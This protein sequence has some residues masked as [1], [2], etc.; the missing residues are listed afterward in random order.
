MNGVMEKMAPAP[1]L[2][3]LDRPGNR[4]IIECHD[5]WKVF[6]NLPAEALAGLRERRLSRAEV[7]ERYGCVV[8]LAGISVRVEQGDICCVM[9]LSGSGKSTLVRH[10]NGL[11][12][13]TSGRVTVDGVD[14]TTAGA[15]LLRQIRSQKIG[16]VFQ[17]FGLLPHRSV[18][19]NVAFGL[20][21]RGVAQGLR[22]HRAREML[23]LVDLDGWEHSY[24]HQ[25]S[26]GMQQRVG[27]ARAL[28]SDPEILLLDEPFGALDP[29]IRRQLKD[30]FVALSRSI[31]KTAVFI[32]HDLEEALRIGT[33]ILIMK[34]GQVVQ[35]GTPGEILLSPA[36]AY[37]AQFVSGIAKSRFL[38]ARD[39]VQQGPAMGDANCQRIDAAASL[40]EAGRL[41]YQSNLP[42]KVVGADGHALGFLDRDR[43]LAAILEETHDR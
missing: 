23:K 26:G 21:L 38:R 20:E 18:I 16:M 39:L 28:A 37:V 42:I 8:G 3:E 2:S 14:I 13:P 25:L 33:R 1:I 27:L 7:M 10:I 12:L 30:Q 17:N 24:P 31:G 43:L 9:G 6:G 40:S 19:S 35:E 15:A 5:L 11:I 41:A 32:T 36:D 22:Y 29:L 4:P 34:D